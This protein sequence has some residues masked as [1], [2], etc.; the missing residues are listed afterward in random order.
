[1][2]HSKSRYDLDPRIACISPLWNHSS[3]SVV[4]LKMRPPATPFTSLDTFMAAHSPRRFCQSRQKYLLK[5]LTLDRKIGESTFALIGDKNPRSKSRI[6]ESKP[7]SPGRTRQLN[8]R[9]RNDSPSGT[10]TSGQDSSS[11]QEQNYT[12]VLPLGKCQINNDEEL[13]DQCGTPSPRFKSGSFRPPPR[14]PFTFNH[15]ASIPS[16]PRDAT[17]LIAIGTIS[18]TSQRQPPPKPMSRWKT[19]AT[20]NLKGCKYSDP[21]AGAGPG[22]QARI[23]EMAQ[24]EVETIKYEKSRKVKKK[25][26]T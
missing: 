15:S 7:K 23:A 13:V 4:T 11:D 24:L 14:L 12:R 8:S 10:S 17:D 22:F 16:S 26:P 20:L 3:G 18:M 1:M 2:A 19:K 5:P 21:L 9:N 25:S 6:E